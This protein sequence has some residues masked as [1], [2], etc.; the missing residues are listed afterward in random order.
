MHPPIPPADA[1]TLTAGEPPKPPPDEVVV[2]AVAA[3][4]DVEPVD[5]ELTAT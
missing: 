1:L 4:L 3:L 5:A 2:A